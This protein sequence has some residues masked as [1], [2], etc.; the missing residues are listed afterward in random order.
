MDIEI[1]KPKMKIREDY[2]IDNEFYR[3]WMNKNSDIS[4]ALYHLDQ[5]VN[6]LLIWNEI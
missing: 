6:Y 2:E 5:V 3:K 4:K 1:L